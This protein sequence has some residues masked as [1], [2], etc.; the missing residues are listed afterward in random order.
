MSTEHSLEDAVSIVTGAGG[1]IGEGIAVE[2]AKAGSDVVVADVDVLDTEYNQQSST[3][4]GGATRAEEVAGRVEEHGRRA[5][6]VECD[7]THA[8][9]VEAMVEETISEF[10]RLDVLC[11]N[12]GIITFD[13]VDEMDEEEWDSVM[14]VNVKG[15]FLPSRAAIPHL[16][17][18]K[19]SII[20]TASIAGTIGAAGLAHYCASKHAVLGLTKS[21][22]LELA[23]DDVTVNAIC[24][25]IVDTPMW[26]KVLT[27]QM[28][29]DYEETVKRAI[30]LGRDQ[31][32]EDMGRL[33]VFYAT[34][35]NV[36]GQALAVDGGI[37]QNVI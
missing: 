37:L 1:Q 18:S 7:V 19:G 13:T 10:G 21:L 29:E 2:L 25:G 27:P 15:V 23:G 31:S 22:S 24:P 6:I 3:E 26:S 20:N 16:K 8:D 4:V 35:R 5:H 33:A 32:P 28:G 12:A 11:N 30:P 9:Q 17:E 14:D 36:T 34:N